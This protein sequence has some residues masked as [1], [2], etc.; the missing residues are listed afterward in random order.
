[1]L[2]RECKKILMDRWFLLFVVV[3]LVLQVVSIFLLH[4]NSYTASLSKNEKMAYYELYQKTM[5]EITKEKIEFLIKENNRL[6]TQVLDRTYSTEFDPDS[7][8][9]YVYSDYSMIHFHLYTPIKRLYEYNIKADEIVKRAN[10]NINFYEKNNNIYQSRL[11][12][13]ISQKYGNRKITKFLELD[14]AESLLEGKVSAILLIVLLCILGIHIWISERENGMIYLLQT[15][16]MGRRKIV[17]TKLMA[18][19]IVCVGLVILF[20]TAKF[21][22]SHILY[23][24]AY[25]T[26]PIYSIKGYE[27]TVLNSSIFIFY[28]IKGLLIWLALTEILLFISA[29]SIR[30]K[31]KITAFLSIVI[32]LI[33]IFAIHNCNLEILK[34]INPM[35]LLF[36]SSLFTR[37]DYINISNYPI[38]RWHVIVVIQVVM[39]IFMSFMIVRGKR[40]WNDKK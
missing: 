24:S 13:K 40:Y 33:F 34:Y 16:Y 7:Y 20:M 19:E 39:S 12:K 1:M 38:A 35:T 22:I 27:D 21:V 28:L 23:G 5:G 4:S 17:S 15:S 30:T 2:I 26:M 31:K 25:L 18:Y 14:G 32:F 6:E 36:D 3:F 37:F 10:E 11:N 9:G 8:T 29:I